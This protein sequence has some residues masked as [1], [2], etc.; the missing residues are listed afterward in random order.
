MK[1]EVNDQKAS[2]SNLNIEKITI[3]SK[4]L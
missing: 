4:E 3:I 1:I 2:I